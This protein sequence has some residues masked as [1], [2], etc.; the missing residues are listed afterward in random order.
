V[1]SQGMDAPRGSVEFEKT[2]ELQNLRPRAD[3]PDADI[4]GDAAAQT[5]LSE[6]EDA[7]RR[8]LP[9]VVDAAVRVPA[10]SLSASQF[11]TAHWSPTAPRFLNAS[12]PVSL[13][14]GRSAR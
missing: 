12:R 14:K 6:L 4:A 8:Q 5:R 2:D 11:L 1:D 7:Q 13:S 9:L 10:L 3:G